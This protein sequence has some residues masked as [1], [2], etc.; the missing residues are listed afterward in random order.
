MFVEVERRRADVG[1]VPVENSTE[2][3]VNVT[4][5]ELIDSELRISGE[6]QIEIHHQLLSRARGLGEVK[7]VF[8][9][10]QALAQCSGWLDRNL[11][12][13]QAIEVASNT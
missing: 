11:P 10:P 1:V 3:A 7:Q 8:A 4:L 5:D 6:I 12:H 13:T 9:H 2:G